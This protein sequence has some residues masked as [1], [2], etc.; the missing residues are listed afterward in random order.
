MEWQILLVLHYAYPLCLCAVLFGTYILLFSRNGA[1]NNSRGEKRIYLKIIQSLQICLSLA[2][3][4]NSLGLR[5]RNLFRLTL[6][7]AS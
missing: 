7:I 1:D 3:V 6:G 2:L 4:Q 5:L